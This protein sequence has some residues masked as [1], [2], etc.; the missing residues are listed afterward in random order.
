[1]FGKILI[2]IIF[3]DADTQNVM[4]NPYFEKS[5][6][7]FKQTAELSTLLKCGSNRVYFH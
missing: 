7:V 5:E 2:T 6:M 3:L 4:D 1:V